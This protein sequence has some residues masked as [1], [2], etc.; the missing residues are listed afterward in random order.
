MRKGS[1]FALHSSSSRPVILFI[2]SGL[3]SLC[4]HH[5]FPIPSQRTT[6]MGEWNDKWIYSTFRKFGVS[7]MISFICQ[8]CIISKVTFTLLQKISILNICGYFELSIHQY[9]AVLKIDDNNKC[10]LSSFGSPKEPFS[11]LYLKVHFFS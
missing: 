1:L 9:W 3:S 4:Q 10:F 5:T 7:K 6:N 8:K 2:F 11:G